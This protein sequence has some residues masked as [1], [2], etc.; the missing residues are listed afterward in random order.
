MD[1]RDDT[2]RLGALNLK[3]A[4][5]EFDLD[6]DVSVSSPVT[7]QKAA[8]AKQFIENHYK[9]YLQGLQDRKERFSSLNFFFLF[10]LE[11]DVC[12]LESC[13]A[14]ELEFSACGFVTYYANVSCIY[15]ID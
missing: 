9:N 6:P 4:A 14:G 8:A 2:V 10:L 3:P 12:R 15:F 7:R 13:K 5:R 11:F 1:G